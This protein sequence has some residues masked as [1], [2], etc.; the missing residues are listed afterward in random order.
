MQITK[1]F[2]I[3]EVK[4]TDASNA[5][6]QIILLHN[7]LKREEESSLTFDTDTRVRYNIPLSFNLVGRTLICSFESR[8]LSLRD[9]NHGNG[10]VDTESLGSDD[11]QIQSLKK[12]EVTLSIFYTIPPSK[13]NQV[14]QTLELSSFGGDDGM[15]VHIMPCPFYRFITELT[16]EEYEACKDLPVNSVFKVS[17]NLV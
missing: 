2:K 11:L 4:A 14:S 1:P 16:D 5:P 17:F 3:C 10:R 7:A 9:D 15:R 13:Y 12:N 8:E 6:F